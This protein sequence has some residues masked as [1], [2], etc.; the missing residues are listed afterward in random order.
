MHDNSQEKLEDK[1]SVVNLHQVNVGIADQRN[2][3][4]SADTELI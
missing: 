3:F 2:T 4:L 1:A